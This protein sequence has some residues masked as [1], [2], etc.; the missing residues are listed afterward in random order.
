MRRVTMAAW[1]R[2][3]LGYTAFSSG[4]SPA[5][6]VQPHSGITQPHIL[7]SIPTWQTG[8]R[9]ASNA[10][11]A[12][13]A[14]APRVR[15]PPASRVDGVSS[16]G[17]VESVNSRHAPAREPRSAF[18]GRSSSTPSAAPLRAGKDIDQK[19]AAADLA[20][21]AASDQAAG[22]LKRDPRT[23]LDEPVARAGLTAAMCAALF[24]LYWYASAK[25][26]P[27]RTTQPTALTDGSETADEGTG[28]SPIA[29]LKALLARVGGGTGHALASTDVGKT[30]T[31][32]TPS[33]ADVA[34]IDEAL[35]SIGAQPP[36]ATNADP[37]RHPSLVEAELLTIRSLRLLNTKDNA[38]ALHDASVA[39]SHF[40]Q[41][42]KEANYDP[43]LH[44]TAQW[45]VARVQAK[46]EREQVTKSSPATSRA[47][48]APVAATVAGKAPPK[49]SSTPAATTPAS[50]RQSHESLLKA[51]T[52]AL[53]ADPQSDESRK[54]VATIEALLS[55]Y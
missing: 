34:D 28:S 49:G 30:I 51:R 39:V 37:P 2:R 7:R 9:F 23:L 15:P 50:L 31:N 33:T 3:S 54:L 11:P 18:G 4:V 5:C 38:G 12:A 14:A 27:H 40:E 25:Q 22:R 35:K 43:M 46:A 48:S 44:A 47:A 17:H 24:G 55:K 29:K 32:A 53:S 6:V 41:C 36:T 1:R 52:L 16:D 19:S 8:E 45:V 13:P 42:T 21:A 26:P 10:A 20:S